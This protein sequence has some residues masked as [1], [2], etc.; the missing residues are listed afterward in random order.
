MTTVSSPDST[1]AQ[2]SIGSL[3][4]L[5]EAALGQ[6]KGAKNVALSFIGCRINYEN[7]DYKNKGHSGY[8]R[9]GALAGVRLAS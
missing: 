8:C 6:G 1:K 3:G 9:Y 2:Q 4:S 5:H 7:V